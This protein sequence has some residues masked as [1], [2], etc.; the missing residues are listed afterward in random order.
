M[1]ALRRRSTP[2]RRAFTGHARGCSRRG[3]RLPCGASPVPTK[4]G[5]PARADDEYGR[6]A[7]ATLFMLFA[8]L[9]G[10]R[11]VTLSER[12]AGADGAA[13]LGDL[14]ERHFPGPS[15][16]PASARSSA[17]RTTSARRPPHRSMP[18]LPQQKPAVWQ[19]GSSGMRRPSMAVG[20]TWPSPNLAPCP[21]NASSGASQTKPASSAESMHG[22]LT[23]TSITAKPPGSSPNE[24]TR[25]T[26]SNLQPSP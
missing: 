6:N 5:Q 2:A 25:M 3:P 13:I 1:S 21:R 14:S 23:E 20:S 4:R 17:S 22:R 9:E 8:P 12:H 11:H 10:W 15:K 24:N 26:L 16:F 18:P 7:T 19:S